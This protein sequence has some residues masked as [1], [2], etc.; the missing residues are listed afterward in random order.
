MM[1]NKWILRTKYIK[2]NGTI[3]CLLTDFLWTRAHWPSP[4]WTLNQSA[5]PL[6]AS[7][8][9]NANARWL[10]FL[11]FGQFS[12]FYWLP[13]SENHDFGLSNKTY[14]QFGILKWLTKHVLLHIWSELAWDLIKPSIY[15]R[16]SE[17]AP[18]NFCCSKPLV[19]N[20]PSKVTWPHE[21][22]TTR[23]WRET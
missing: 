5:R 17:A 13:V 22:N 19:F 23:F 3:S 9:W 20:W 16:F 4:V 10:D 15:I 18:F 2:T 7:R 21:W 8:N 6:H 11:E 14:L 12:Y 1:K